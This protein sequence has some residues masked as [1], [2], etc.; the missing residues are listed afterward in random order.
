LSSA[1]FIWFSIAA[2][3][4]TLINI[5]SYGLLATCAFLAGGTALVV[6]YYWF[7]AVVTL[8]GR[9]QSNP[10]SFANPH[11]FL[12]LI[13][14][15]NE[16]KV[17]GKTISALK[18]LDYPKELYR[19]VVVA[20][21]C[22]DETARI[23]RESGSICLERTD[24]KNRGK[25]QA[26][27]WAFEQLASEIFDAVIVLDADCFIDLHALKVF[28]RYLDQGWMVLQSR[29]AA[30][31]PD[32]SSMSYA[33]AV[34]N[35]LENDF[36]YEPK[37]RLGLAVLLRGTGFVLAREV[38]ISLPWHA[39]SITEDIEYSVSLIRN[40][41]PIHFIPEVEVKSKF[42]SSAGQLEVQRK[43][44]AEGNIGFGRK[45]ALSLIWHG[46]LAGNWRL[47]DAGWTFLVLSKPLMLFS[48]LAALVLSN[49]CWWLTPGKL[50]TALL[51]AGLIIMG[52]MI[53]Y[54]SLGIYRLGIDLHRIELLCRAPF[55]ILKLF[56]IALKSLFGRGTDKWVRTPR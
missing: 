28:G 34:G 24:L 7:L 32:D 56:L 33:V 5:I 15:H 11:T 55:V 51:W 44:W 19:V 12:I 14:A 40:H 25:G 39:A 13:P 6:S 31:N 53:S 38:L 21:N 48:V 49:L 29:N 17:L 3:Q 37:S 41:M 36:F 20:D 10:P 9:K 46:F 16:E 23:A 35:L 30:S 4:Q 27:S 18:D 2:S 8:T 45:N 22:T 26:L 47:V 42:P 52:S 43:R 54:L 50:S 1:D